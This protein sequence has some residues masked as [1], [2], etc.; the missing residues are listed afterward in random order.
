MAKIASIMRTSAIIPIAAYSALFSVPQRALALSPQPKRCSAMV[1]TRNCMSIIQRYSTVALE[2]KRNPKQKNDDEDTN[3]LFARLDN[4][5]KIATTPTPLVPNL[6][7]GYPLV[8]LLATVLFPPPVAVS[9]VWILLF[10]IFRSLGGIFTIEAEQ[11]KE[12][13]QPAAPINLLAFVAAL[14]CSLLLVPTATTISP[15]PVFTN[16]ATPG[17]SQQLVIGA[18]ALLLVSSGLQE[19]L[20]G[21]DIDPPNIS[22]PEQE[23]MELWDDELKR[24]T[25]ANKKQTMNGDD[26]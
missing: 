21:N 4:L 19:V 18:A 8:F 10:G 11:D 17:I 3:T 14:L 2:A 22:S 5:G 12:A 9:L 24:A 23:R 15:N 26:D 13:E 7:L 16:D 1:P 6:P 25:T 20:L